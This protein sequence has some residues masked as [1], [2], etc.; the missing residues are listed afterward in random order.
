MVLYSFEFLHLIRMSNFLL[1]YFTDTYVVG[2]SKLSLNSSSW[3]NNL[4]GQY[5]GLIVRGKRRLPY[6]QER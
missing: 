4:S 5:R 2:G 1:E 3:A 6:G